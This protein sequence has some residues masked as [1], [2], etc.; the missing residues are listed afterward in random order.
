EIHGFDI[1]IYHP[2]I[3]L[4]KLEITERAVKIGTFPGKSPGLE[5][6]AVPDHPR[7]AVSRCMVEESEKLF[8]VAGIVADAVSRMRILR[9]S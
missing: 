3:G 4:D 2:L 7:T 8:D 5:C 9:V 6:A 1:P